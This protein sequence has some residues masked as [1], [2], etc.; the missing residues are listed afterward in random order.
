VSQCRPVVFDV[1]IVRRG[2][3]Y[4]GPKLRELFGRQRDQVGDGLSEGQL[5]IDARVMRANLST[6]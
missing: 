4:F 1:R 6:P 2:G 3:T 5:R